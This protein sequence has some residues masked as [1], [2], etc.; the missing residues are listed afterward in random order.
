MDVVSELPYCE[1]YGCKRP[2]HDDSSANLTVHLLPD[3]TV[4]V[5]SCLYHQAMFAMANGKYLA[6]RTYRGE[7]EMR[8]VPAVPAPPA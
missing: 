6:A 2:Q 3:E 8:P 1:F 4:E 7:I 5:K